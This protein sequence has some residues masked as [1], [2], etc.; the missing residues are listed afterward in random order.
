MPSRFELAYVAADGSERTP[1][2]IHRAMLGSF[3]RFL[4]ILIEHLGGAFP[5]WLAPVQVAVLPV[6]ERFLAY[7]KRV[8]EH[9][10]KAGLRAE[11]DERGEKLGFKIREAQVQKIPYMLVVGAREE[12]SGTASVRSRSGGDLGAMGV[13]RFVESC[14]EKVA[15]RSLDL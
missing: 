3:E 5:L 1:V 2:M 4:G 10:V 11:V 8:G 9:L 6:S 7:G 15:A 13:D 12:E 14:R